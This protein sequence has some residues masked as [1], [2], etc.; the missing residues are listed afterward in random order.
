MQA[1][2][3]THGA[4]VP[5]NG[6]RGGSRGTPLSAR[7]DHVGAPGSV[8]AERRISGQG[9]AESRSQS[10]VNSYSVAISSA[11]LSMIICST[12]PLN[13]GNRSLHP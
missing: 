13:S 3:G 4:S 12:L 11:T 8:Q 1:Y 7:G 10:R 5:R 6:R 2:D 9:A